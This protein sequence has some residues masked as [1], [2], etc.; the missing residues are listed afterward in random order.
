MSGQQKV[1]FILAATGAVI[2][3]VVLAGHTNRGISRDDGLAIGTASL[4]GGGLLYLAA[5]P[6][7]ASG[8]RRRGH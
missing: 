4:I 2:D 8:L 3:T 7:Q 1:G 6:G 5:S